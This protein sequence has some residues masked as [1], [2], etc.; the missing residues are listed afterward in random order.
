MN[1]KTVHPNYREFRSYDITKT[2]DKQ[3]VLDDYH[4]YVEY[5]QHIV[6]FENHISLQD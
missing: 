4:S 5:G 3:Y 2:L 1:L 6:V